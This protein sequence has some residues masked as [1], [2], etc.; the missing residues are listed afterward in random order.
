[1][2]ATINESRLTLQ[3]LMRAIHIQLHNCY[4]PESKS[5]VMS[6][7]DPVGSTSVSKATSLIRM[8]SIFPDFLD[9]LQRRNELVLKSRLQ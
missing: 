7:P 3:V 1:M 5:P 6:L 4:L 2:Q 9:N 8:S